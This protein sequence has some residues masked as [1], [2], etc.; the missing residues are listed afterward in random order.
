M[1]FQRYALINIYVKYFHYCLVNWDYIIVCEISC[2]RKR[3]VIKFYFYSSILCNALT[4]PETNKYIKE[5][6]KKLKI[7][8]SLFFK[9]TFIFISLTE[10]SHWSQQRFSPKIFQ[11]N[12]ENN[13]FQQ[14]L[15][16]PLLMYTIT[17][18]TLCTKEKS[19][20]CSNILS[21]T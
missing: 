19:K 18:Y 17:I 14:P 13:I 21:T 3:C 8:N 5:V 4:I 9:S 6:T 1:N 15:L 7:V 2:Y 11:T 20:T 16:A 12:F 10:R